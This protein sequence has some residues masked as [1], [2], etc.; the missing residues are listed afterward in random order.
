MT[1][2]QACVTLCYA[3]ISITNTCFSSVQ[4]LPYKLLA[5]QQDYIQ[6]EKN[7]SSF[8]P[9]KSKMS[10]KTFTWKELG[11]HNTQ[12]DAFVAVR[13][14]VRAYAYRTIEEY[15]SHIQGHII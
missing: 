14:K 7:L 9:C 15:L 5:S 2:N 8:K 1:T 13:G 6:Q 3:K 10:K 4:A 11:Q 12:Q